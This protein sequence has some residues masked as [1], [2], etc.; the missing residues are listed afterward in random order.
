MATLTVSDVLNEIEAPGRHIS[1]RHISTAC[2]KCGRVLTLADC[3]VTG[4]D[5]LVY[6]CPGCGSPLV[7]IRAPEGQPRP[8]RGIRIGKFVI[9]AAVNLWVE[10]SNRFRP[11]KI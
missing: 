5:R 6:R 10:K 3:R 8:E 7:T 4:I 9:Q 2:D 11:A 1:D